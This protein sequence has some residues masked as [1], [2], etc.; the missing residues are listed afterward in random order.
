MM[1]RTNVPE[2]ISPRKWSGDWG[3]CD[4]HVCGVIAHWLDGKRICGTR[5]HSVPCECI[6]GKREPCRSGV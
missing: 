6:C 5:T 1:K 2:K 3:H 4:P